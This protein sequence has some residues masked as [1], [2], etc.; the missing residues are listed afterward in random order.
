MHPLRTPSY[1]PG[2]PA[3]HNPR[4]P[5]R[6]GGAWRTTRCGTRG[7]GTTARDR[8][9]GMHPGPFVLLTLQPCLWTRRRRNQKIRAKHLPT[10]LPRVCGQHRLSE[11]KRSY[12]GEHA[13]SPV[14][15]ACAVCLCSVL[16]VLQ[17]CRG[18]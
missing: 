17:R 2:H 15:L 8:V 14:S 9:N 7:R 13:D 1:P 4:G 10:V 11:G 16:S 3:C 12:R 6:S 5:R 18:V